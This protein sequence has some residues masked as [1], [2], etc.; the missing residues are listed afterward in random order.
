MPNNKKELITAADYSNVEA[1][2][3]MAVPSESE[4]EIMCHYFTGAD[5]PPEEPH[6]CRGPMGD[7]RHYI[8]KAGKMVMAHKRC[9]TLATEGIKGT[10]NIS[11]R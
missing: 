6:H 1:K 7:E 2:G 4:S 5:Y 8:I 10:P 3:E 11:I 9:H